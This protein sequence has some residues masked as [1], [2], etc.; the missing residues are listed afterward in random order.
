MNIEFGALL[1]DKLFENR[2]ILAGERGL[3]RKVKRVSVFDCPCVPDILERKILCEGDLFITCLEQFRDEPDDREI[4]FYL[5]CLIRSRSAG[6]LVITDD[7]LEVLTPDLLKMCDDSGFPV[8]LIPEDYPYTVILDTIHNYITFDTYNTINKLRLD[9]IMYEDLSDAARCDVLYSIKPTIRKYVRAIFIQGAFNSDIAQLELQNY[10]LN[11]ENDIFVRT[12][13]GMIILLSEDDEEKTSAS[14]D[15]CLIRIRE[16]LDNPVIG[17]SR[18]FPRKNCGRAL[19]EAR[20]ALETARAMRMTVRTY[21]ALSS[22]QLLT[23]IKDTQAAED[24]YDAY[25][26]A[27]RSRITEENLPEMI[28]TIET[29]VA[30]CGDFRLTAEMMNQHVNTI[31]YRINRA[32]SA[33]NMEDDTIRFNET[34]A[35]AVKLRVLLNREI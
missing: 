22:I 12:E 32:K 17:Y 5:D 30:N 16:F 33:L 27:L 11:R 14:L 20:R 15:A 29:Y 4:R 19:E 23:T 7:R 26:A 21:D 18:V 25:L 28:L 35:I 3:D 24:Y 34:I 10:Y 13:Q 8:A 2:K 31:R 1:R 9:K 6:L